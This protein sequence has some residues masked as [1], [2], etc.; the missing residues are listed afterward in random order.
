MNHDQ[1]DRPTVEPRPSLD[2]PFDESICDSRAWLVDGAAGFCRGRSVAAGAGGFCF[3]C[4]LD[5]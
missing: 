5:I 3:D 2:V 1:P 4:G